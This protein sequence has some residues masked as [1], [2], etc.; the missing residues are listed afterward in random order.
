MKTAIEYLLNAVEANA[1][2]WV[3]FRDPQ[4]YD[5]FLNLFLDVSYPNIH[6][7]QIYKAWPWLP[8]SWAFEGFAGA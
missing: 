2:E 6:Q 1:K 7:F 3:V 4:N 5:R 8:F